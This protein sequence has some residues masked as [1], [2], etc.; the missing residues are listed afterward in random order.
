MESLY[1][2][3]QK[4][5]NALDNAE[6][7]E[8]GEFTSAELETIMQDR[9]SK[10]ENIGLY[11]KNNEHFCKMLKAEEESLAERRKKRE[12]KNEW[13]KQYAANSIATFGTI[14]TSRIKMTIRKSESIEVDEKA[15]PAEYMQPKVTFT[16]DKTAIKEKLKQGETVAGATIITK[17]NLQIK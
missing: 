7:D 2:I 10:L 3:D 11:I 1:D 16:P 9:E 6:P 14:E 15:L 4:L 17:F 12:R 8:N 5:L 13:L